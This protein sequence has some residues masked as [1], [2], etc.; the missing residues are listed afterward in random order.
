VLVEAARAAQQSLGPRWA[1]GQRI[2]A[3]RSLQ[4]AAVAVP[5]VTPASAAED[6]SAGFVEEKRWRPACQP[7]FHGLR[8]DRPLRLVRGDL[9]VHGE[10]SPCPHRRC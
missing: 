8:T 10:E 5:A 1:F 7:A 9:V 2:K 3:R 6:E 4:V